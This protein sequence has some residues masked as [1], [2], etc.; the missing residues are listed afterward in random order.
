MAVPNPGWD[1]STAA[2]GI[3]AAPAARGSGIGSSMGWDCNGC[4]CGISAGPKRVGCVAEAA[5]A[6]PAAEAVRVVNAIG[7]EAV[8]IRKAA[9]TN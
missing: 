8:C 9:G 6:T 5:A 2:V 3:I 1:C 4:V 7:A